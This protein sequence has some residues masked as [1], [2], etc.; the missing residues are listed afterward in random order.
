MG[1]VTNSFEKGFD[2][3][4]L[5]KF[6]TWF[7]ILLILLLIADFVP[8]VG[9]LATIA[10]VFV[11]EFMIMPKVLTKYNQKSPFGEANFA[12][13]LAWL[14][15]SVIQGILPLIN[16]RQKKVLR[17]QL[18]LIGG[19]ILFGILG[20]AVNPF[21]FLFMGLLLVV[22]TIL[23]FYNTLRY[24]Q[25]LPV[26]LVEKN[27]TF[28]SFDRSW[29]L[30]EGKALNVFALELLLGVFSLVVFA[31][32]F[33]LVLFVLLGDLVTSV[34]GLL[35]TVSDPLAAFA[36]IGASIILLNIVISVFTAFLSLV[37]LFAKANYYIGLKKEFV[38]SRRKK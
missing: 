34:E 3:L 28:I 7:A 37:Y 33:V 22:G 14:K 17:W 35:S 38:P 13:F 30:T 12:N 18:G 11:I 19:V 15:L 27:S 36:V 32:I 5:S 25:V 4:K 29:E 8:F 26:R 24:S 20:F 31:V 2:W 9:F 10:M 21:L 1:L 6:Y 23:S 16:W